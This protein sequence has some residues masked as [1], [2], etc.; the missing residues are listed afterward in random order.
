M[1]QR[2]MR[3]GLGEYLSEIWIRIPL[4]LLETQQQQSAY[5][6]QPNLSSSLVLGHEEMAHG[7]RR[8]L[9]A[10]KRKGLG[11]KS[12]RKVSEKTKGEK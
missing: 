11:E 9:V 10:E 2:R 8:K 5:N 1:K 4:L 3:Q 6:A 7:G 12:R